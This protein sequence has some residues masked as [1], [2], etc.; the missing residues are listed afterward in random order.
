MFEYARSVS[1]TDSQVRFTFTRLCVTR[2][3]IFRNDYRKL[4]ILIHFVI[5][6]LICFL[7]FGKQL[8]RFALPFIHS[9]SDATGVFRNAFL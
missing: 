9:H 4:S 2:L 5:H 6:F 7:Y 1:R 3:L 8:R